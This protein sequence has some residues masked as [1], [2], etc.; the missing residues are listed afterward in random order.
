M[1]GGGQWRRDGNDKEE[2]GDNG[3]DD[4]GGGAIAWRGLYDDDGTAIWVASDS[5]RQLL[6]H[7]SEATV[8]SWWQFGEEERREWGDIGGWDD[9]YG[10]GGGNSVE[11]L[12]LHEIASKPI[13]R[14]PQSSKRAGT[15]SAC[16]LGVRLR[17]PRHDQL[18]FRAQSEAWMTM[19]LSVFLVLEIFSIFNFIFDPVVAPKCCRNLHRQPVYHFIWGITCAWCFISRITL[20]VDSNLLCHTLSFVASLFKFCRLESALVTKRVWYLR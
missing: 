13:F 2:D 19:A 12:E 11:I 15:Y 9:R 3:V 14:S 8:N 10:R 4:D 17:Y 20:V 18:V 1:R 6:C 7:P 5:R 16:I